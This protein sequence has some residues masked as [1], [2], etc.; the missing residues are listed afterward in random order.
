[1]AESVWGDQAT[2]F[3]HAIG[4]D[5]ILRCVD[6]L[7]FRSTGRVLALN[8]LENRVYEVEIENPNAKTNSEKFIIAKFY[9]PGRWSEAQILEEHQFLFDLQEE[10][11]AVIAPLQIEGKSLFFMSGIFYALFPKQ[12]GRNPDEYDDEFLERLGRTLGRMH[13]VGKSKQANH[14]LRINPT[15]YGIKNLE[16]LVENKLITPNL[17]DQYR[18]LVEEICKMATPAF[19]KLEVQRIHGDCHRGNV[20]WRPE[21][22]YLI[23]FDDMVVGP[24][25][26]DIWLILPGRDGESLEYRSKLLAAYE[27]FSEFDDSSLRL[28]ETLRALRYIHFSAWIGKRYDDHSFKRA[29]PWYGTPEYWREQ[30][31]DLIDQKE[32]INR[33]LF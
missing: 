5:E 18:K 33:E 20:L 25:V 11:I 24:P 22:I 17:E 30:V 21:G 27:D 14:R 6:L 16:Y 29:F 9:R 8:S 12:G 31:Q 3:F 15:N 2:Q 13:Q 23:D 1:M 32:F 28:V 4:A 10:E 7:G 19:D 26:Q